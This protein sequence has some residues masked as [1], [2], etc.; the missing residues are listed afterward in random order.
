[1]LDV[2]VL[3][4]PGTV[5]VCRINGELIAREAP[6]LRRACQRLGLTD[7]ITIDLRGVTRLDSPGLAAF[8]G[9]LRRARQMARFVDVRNVPPVVLSRLRAAGFD[10]LVPM[11]AVGEP[12]T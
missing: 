5:T 10:R 2:A 8:A 4:H 6:V 9:L 1:M 3:Q 11:A 7:R 12:T